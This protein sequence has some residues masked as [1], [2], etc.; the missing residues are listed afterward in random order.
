MEVRVA[1]D[2]VLVRVRVAGNERISGVRE[3]FG[4]ERRVFVTLSR[5]VA[6]GVTF[7]RR[8]RRVFV[9]LSLS[10]LIPPQ[11]L[12]KQGFLFI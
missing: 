3:I 10:N 11:P 1:G 2:L 12:P 7:E 9:T 4:N 6:E 8:I 5:G